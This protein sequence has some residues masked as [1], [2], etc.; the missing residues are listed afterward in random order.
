M[1]RDDGRKRESVQKNQTLLN[2]LIRESTMISIEA[3][4]EGREE[5]KNRQEEQRVIA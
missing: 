1:K 2:M 5:H 3:K 4:K